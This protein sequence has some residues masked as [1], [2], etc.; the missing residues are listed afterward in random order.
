MVQKAPSSTRP[1]MVQKMKCDV[2]RSTFPAFET[3]QSCGMMEK[4]SRYWETIQNMSKSQLLFASECVTSAKP[5]D[6]TKMI[7]LV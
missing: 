7:H 1:M 3:I 6:A 5:T 4:P 2:Q